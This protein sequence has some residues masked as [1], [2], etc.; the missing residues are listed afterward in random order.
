MYLWEQQRPGGPKKGL[1]MQSRPFLPASIISNP[2]TKYPRPALGGGRF[3]M[4]QIRSCLVT[5]P[6]TPLLDWGPLHA[7]SSR[8]QEFA[9]IVCW[10]YTVGC[11]WCWCNDSALGLAGPRPRNGHRTSKP[12]ASPSPRSVSRR[13][14]EPRCHAG[15]TSRTRT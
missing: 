4:M 8:A 7:W 13:R 15:P 5:N 14:V 12:A 3:G 1:G 2:W 9:T 6:H 11:K 10:M